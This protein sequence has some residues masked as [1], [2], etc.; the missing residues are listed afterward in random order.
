MNPRSTG[1]TLKTLQKLSALYQQAYSCPQSTED[2]GTGWQQ[3]QLHERLMRSAL[4]WL[5]APRLLADMY[6]SCFHQ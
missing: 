3:Q 5:L 1:I 4:P 6:L 2:E